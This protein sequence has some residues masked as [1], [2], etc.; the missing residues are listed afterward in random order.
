MYSFWIEK[1]T[2]MWSSYVFVVNHK[3]LCD[4]E[5]EDETRNIFLLSTMFHVQ[6]QNNMG[7]K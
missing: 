1:F 4:N 5:I 7:Q 2:N 3:H 6:S